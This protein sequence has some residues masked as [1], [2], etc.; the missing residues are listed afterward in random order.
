C[1]RSACERLGTSAFRARERKGAR[2]GLDPAIEYALAD[3]RHTAGG[4][5]VDKELTARERQIADLVTKG[6]SNRAVATKL[7]LSQQAVHENIGE[8]FANLGVRSRK[9]SVEWVR[10]HR[11]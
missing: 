6:L 1:E 9:Q 10:S 3:G 4:V 11:G 5:Y 7:S 8:M 2:L